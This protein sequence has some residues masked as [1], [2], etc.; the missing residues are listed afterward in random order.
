MTTKHWYRSKTIWLLVAQLLGVWAAFV[1]GEAS[2]VATVGISMTA[3][4][5]VIIRVYSTEQP[6]QRTNGGER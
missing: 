4:S 2:F 5:G 3:I 6:I 1:T